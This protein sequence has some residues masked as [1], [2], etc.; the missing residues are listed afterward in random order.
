MEGFSALKD[1]KDL[2]DTT[3]DSKDKWRNLALLVLI[4]IGF[5]AFRVY[6][7][8][9]YGELVNNILSSILIA[10][11]MG[12]IYLLVVLIRSE[13]AQISPS[14]RV[15]SPKPSLKGVYIA[16]L[17]R[18]EEDVRQVQSLVKT[19]FRD[20]GP[21]DETIRQIWNH[22][23]QMTVLVF[24]VRVEQRRGPVMKLVGFATAW[25]MKKDAYEALWSEKLQEHQINVNHV[26]DT[27]QNKVSRAL[28]VP[29]IG[30]AMNKYTDEHRRAVGLK[31]SV[32]TVM[33]FLKLLEH[34]YFRSE[35]ETKELCAVAYTREGG[36][37]FRDIFAPSRLSLTR[38]GD[39]QKELLGAKVT[40]AH[41]RQKR[42]ELERRYDRIHLFTDF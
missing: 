2:W 38:I 9:G 35:T 36:E 33:A 13:R 27:S 31:K 6:V 22:N 8:G 12:T 39:A 24:E 1:L 21:T 3:K 16:R 17:I 26:L 29:A 25:P 37:L 11:G 28:Y 42:A 41:V 4:V 14:A 34:C 23:R 20:P 7:Q 19:I 10:M 32:A 30:V 15:F 5:S 18:D 40:C